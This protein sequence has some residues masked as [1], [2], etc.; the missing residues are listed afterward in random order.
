[1]SGEAI[2]V[3]F[4]ALITGLLGFTAITW[5]TR[6]GFKTLVQS[7]K[8]QAELDRAARQH[9][10]QLERDA[11]AAH[12][13]RERKA[14]AASL[15]GELFYLFE[16]VHRLRQIQR[17]AIKL[18]AYGQ[19]ENFSAHRLLQNFPTPVY[20]ESVHRLGILSPTVSA[21]VS[22][23]W[24]HFRPSTET[25]F[26]SDDPAHNVAMIEEYVASNTVWMK[27]AAHVLRRLQFIADDTPDPGPLFN[28]L[29]QAAIADA[30]A[31]S[32]D[33]DSHDPP[34]T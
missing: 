20:T 2:A 7:Q 26:G 8:Q 18:I 27:N 30:L 6:N 17:D 21:D 29:L 34:V 14:L 22:I 5:Q 12:M 16:R 23:I 19:L 15:M 13:I 4:A 32:Q 33:S 10:F 25:L 3:I 24:G 11:E 1:M 9:Q 28:T 31:P